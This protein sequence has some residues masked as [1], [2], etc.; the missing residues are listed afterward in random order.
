MEFDS[1]EPGDELDWLVL[2]HVL[3][4][5][6]GLRSLGEAPYRQGSE[7]FPE[8]W[9]VSHDMAFAWRVVEHATAAGLQVTLRYAPDP[10]KPGWE[11]T[12]SRA[13]G[14]IASSDAQTAPL[15]ICRAAL[16]AVEQALL[17]KSSFSR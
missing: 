11:A 2:H 12:F 3:D 1:L 15:A 10:R 13:Q 7:M 6:R 5:K 14:P 8:L 16:R 9:P 4:W 17:V